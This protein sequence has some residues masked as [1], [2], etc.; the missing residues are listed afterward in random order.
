MSVISD[1][2]T[3]K[4]SHKLSQRLLITPQLRQALYLLQLPPLKEIADKTHLHLST[5]ARITANKYIAAPLGTYYLKNL[6]GR[7]FESNKQIPVS[8]K[9]ILSKIQH[10]IFKEHKENPLTYQIIAN[11][12]NKEGIRISRR[13]I[14]KYRDK[15]KIPPPI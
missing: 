9:N 6:F 12:L 15:L 10:I 5:V 14:A 11:T 3:L 7:K 8:D 13:T 1:M 2:K 4:I